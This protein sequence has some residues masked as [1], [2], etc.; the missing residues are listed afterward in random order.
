[1]T[2]RPINQTDYKLAMVQ[3]SFNSYMNTPAIEYWRE[4]CLREG[5]ARHYDKGDH[6]FRQ[7]EVAKYLGLVVSGTLIYTV[8]GADGIE[9]VIGLE[10][11]DEFVSDLPFSITGTPARASVIAQSPCEILCVS[12]Q[13]L[14]E[15]MNNDPVLR[16]T[17]RVTTE[18]VFGTLYDRHAAL[19][20]KTPEE[21]YTDLINH[22]PQ[23]FQHFSLKV[24]ASLLNITPT[25]LSRIR[26]RI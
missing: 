14:R 25:S 10:Y 6:F 20:T 21:R 22:D 5:V 13:T 8:M 15:R 18:A 2:H 17:I 7:G 16:E 3:H 24:I 11:A 26:K 12:T 23:L 4:L 9:H 1:M 19:Y